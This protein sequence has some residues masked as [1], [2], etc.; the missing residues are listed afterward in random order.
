MELKRIVGLTFL[1]SVILFSGPL[2][3]VNASV[4]D[5]KM[6]VKHSVKEELPNI[7]ILATGGTIA[8]SSESSTDTTGYES[9][10]LN[11]KTIIKAVPQLKKIANVSGEQ[12]VNIGSQNIDNSILLKLAKRINTL[13]ASKDVD[14]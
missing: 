9:G 12:V 8:G 4:N 10:A 11:I 13:L 5:S 14:G 2:S 1:S 6:T 7:K 3:L